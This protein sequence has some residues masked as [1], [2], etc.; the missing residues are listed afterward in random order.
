MSGQGEPFRL[1]IERKVEKD[2]R[3]CG[4]AEAI[5]DEWCGACGGRGIGL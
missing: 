1:E 4:G 2:C 3:V 5:D